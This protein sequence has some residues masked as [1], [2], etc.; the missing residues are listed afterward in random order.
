MVLGSVTS[1]SSLPSTGQHRCT[2]TGQLIG[3][4]VAFRDISDRLQAEEALARSEARF[5][6]IVQHAG[7][8]IV[9]LD[10][11]L[12]IR[13]VSPSSERMTGY[14]PEELVGRACAWT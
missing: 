3:S 1:G 14:R 9:I 12:V 10:E 13:F 7:D 8:A 11:T 2:V 6:S 5:R 4:V